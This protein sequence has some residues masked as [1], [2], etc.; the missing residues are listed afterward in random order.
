MIVLT[1]LAFAYAESR[2]EQTPEFFFFLFL[3]S[4]TPRGEMNGRLENNYYIVKS[5]FIM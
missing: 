1:R 5:S 2:V 3:A 4:M